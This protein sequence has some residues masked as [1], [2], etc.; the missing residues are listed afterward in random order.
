[1]PQKLDC[2]HVQQLTL[3]NLSGATSLLNLFW[4]ASRFKIE[5]G[6]KPVRFFIDE[7][8][9]NDYKL[10]ELKKAPV[11]ASNQLWPL[12]AKH[13]SLKSAIV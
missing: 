10:A 7:Y 4:G 11:V 13:F 5:G 3:Q 2:K 8:R 6:I 1:M 9:R 12:C